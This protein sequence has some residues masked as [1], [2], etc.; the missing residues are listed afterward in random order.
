MYNKKDNVLPAHD[1]LSC[2]LYISFGIIKPQKE[3]RCMM[4]YYFSR[5]SGRRIVHTAECVYIK[6]VDIDHV[7]AFETL[8][9]A[10]KSRYRLCR[11]CNSLR[12][13][14]KRELTSLID[15]SRRNAIPFRI[16]DRCV[17]IYTPYSK[18]RIASIENTGKFI[19]YHKNM[20]IQTM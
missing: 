3:K 19:L 13:Q 14:Y 11:C 17:W 4:L 1:L 20:K 15:F 16:D 10:Y 8:D 9:E 2:F 18:W 7:G 6:N 12:K 5:N